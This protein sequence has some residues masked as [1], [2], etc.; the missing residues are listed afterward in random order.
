MCWLELCSAET[1]SSDCQQRENHIEIVT[2]IKVNIFHLSFN[3]TFQKYRK[4]PEIKWDVCLQNTTN[5][6]C[7]SGKVNMQKKKCKKH[8]HIKFFWPFFPTA[9]GKR[10]CTRNNVYLWRWKLHLS[11]HFIAYTHSKCPKINQKLSKIQ[12]F[13]YFELMIKLLNIF[14]HRPNRPN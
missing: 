1:Q 14:L 9:F 6:Y 10:T 3:L 5:H 4:T 11:K 2:E 7:C 12:A 8:L 13:L